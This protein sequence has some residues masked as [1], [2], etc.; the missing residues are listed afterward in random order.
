MFLFD[1]VGVKIELKDQSQQM[2]SASVTWQ[3]VLEGAARSQS[4][5]NIAYM[6]KILN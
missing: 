1:V 6:L 4:T 5:L 2:S 3:N